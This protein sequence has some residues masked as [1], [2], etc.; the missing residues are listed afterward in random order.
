MTVKVSDPTGTGIAHAQIRLVP[1]PEPALPKLETDDKGQLSLNLKPGEYALFVGAPGF[2][3]ARIHLEVAPRGADSGNSQLV[4]VKLDV[5]A[6]GSPIVYPKDSL[7]ITAEPYHSPVILSP[8][9]FRALPH[10]EAKVHNSHS[11][12]DETFSG[13]PLATLLAKANA[14][15]GKELRK[16]AYTVYVIAS[17]SDGY[18]VLLSLAEI[19][20]DFHGGQVLVADMRD[21]KPLGISGPFQLIVSDD[22]RPARWV[23]NLQS[24]TLKNAL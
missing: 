6:T 18:S 20:P 11:D 15:V 22:K 12:K 9:D 21:G 19:D 10:V 2:N 1:A 14:P 3:S 5:G 8:A 17:G 24:L 23:R 16:E 7:V 13:V 4:P